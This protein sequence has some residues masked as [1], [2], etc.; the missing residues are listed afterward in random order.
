M[1]ILSL[2]VLAEEVL[3]DESFSRLSV[4]AS[5]LDVGMTQLFLEVG[6]VVEHFYLLHGELLLRVSEAL[7]AG[8]IISCLSE[9]ILVKARNLSLANVIFLTVVEVDLIAARVLQF[10]LGLSLD[11]W[12]LAH[13]FDQVRLAEG[14][15][16]SN[17]YKVRGSLVVE[18][19]LLLVLLALSPFKLLLD[20]AIAIKEEH[21]L[22]HLEVLNVELRHQIYQLQSLKSQQK[23][24]V[25]VRHIEHIHQFREQVRPESPHIIC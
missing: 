7:V 17:N 3:L 11:V 6:C 24:S 13:E 8:R 9:L 22:I 2:F 23:I 10:R 25:L 20:H 12:F 16:R 18:Q 5:T 15:F 14:V 1:V 21:P 4:D 19:L